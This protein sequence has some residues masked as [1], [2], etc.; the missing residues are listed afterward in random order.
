MVENGM[1]VNVKFE[2]PRVIGE[3]AGC[4]GEIVEGETIVEF[5]DGLMIHY[6]RYC[7]MAFC[8]E[9]GERKTVWK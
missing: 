2:E 6:D 1:T 3:C 8:L 4:Y 7:A 5:P 9:A